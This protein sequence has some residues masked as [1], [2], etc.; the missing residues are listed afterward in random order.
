MKY[1]SFKYITK[2]KS[3]RAVP[4]DTMK[5]EVLQGNLLVPLFGDFGQLVLPIVSENHQR[6]PSKTFKT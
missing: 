2:W 3:R 5:E 1:F 4:E 6:F